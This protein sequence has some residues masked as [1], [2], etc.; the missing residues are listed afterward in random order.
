MVSRKKRRE[1]FRIVYPFYMLHWEEMLSYADLTASIFGI[2]QVN[3]NFQ[4]EQF[5]TISF[6]L[7][8]IYSVRRSKMDLI[9]G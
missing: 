7:G 2:L 1:F 4:A 5:Q 6:L 3:S 9:A 8:S